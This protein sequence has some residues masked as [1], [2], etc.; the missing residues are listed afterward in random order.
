[1]SSSAEKTSETLRADFLHCRR[2]TRRHA[3]SFYLASF[4]LPRQKRDAP[5]ALYAFCRRMDDTVDGSTSPPDAIRSAVARLESRVDEVYAGRVPE[6]PGGK[7]LASVVGRY[8]IPE[9][10]F[11]ELARGVLQDLEVSRYATVAE[12]CGYAHRVAGVVGVMMAHVFGATSP[13]ALEAAEALG[14]A[15]QL[16]NILRDV[17]E[18]WRASRLY[19]PLE[20]LTRFGLGEADVALG[21]VDDRWRELLRHEIGRARAYYA[22]AALGLPLLPDDGSRLTV[23]AMARLY[24]GILREI[25]RCDYDV[26]AARRSVPTPRK[27]KLLFAAW[28]DSVRS[29]SRP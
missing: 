9:Y 14:Q 7:A 23:A 19:L 5:Y 10:A 15:M 21:C 28:R 16:T 22:R 18:D 3:R 6:V 2:V 25:E 13:A 8:A 4:F 17:A 26:F 27:L 11:R 20:C 29:A 24:G 12:L 1:V